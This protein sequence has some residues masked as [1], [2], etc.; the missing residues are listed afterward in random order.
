MSTETIPPLAQALGRVSSGL[1][2][3]TTAGADGPLGF[4]GSFVIQVGFEPPT[5]AVAIA[6]G[7]DHVAAIRESGHFGLSILD[8]PS[9]GLMGAFFKKL[10]E[11][12]TPFDDLKLLESR[13]GVPVLAD[14]LAW[15]DCRVT[16]EHKPCEHVVLFGE[17]VEGALLRDGT[18]SSHV[19]KNGLSY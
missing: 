15:L 13:A 3:V 1:Y 2:I 19:R 12:Q 10:P 17:V 18:P 14:S 9:S 5:V 16:S 7:R 11:G 4:L 6:D 8:K